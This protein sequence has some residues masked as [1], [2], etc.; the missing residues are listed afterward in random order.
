M[1][2]FV[3]K[4]PANLRGLRVFYKGINLKQSRLL[5]EFVLKFI[6]LMVV[7]HTHNHLYVVDGYYDPPD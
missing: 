3:T 7:A 5:A 1:S 6:I 2:L 4:K